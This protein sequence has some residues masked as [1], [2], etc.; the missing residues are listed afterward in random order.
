DL[1]AGRLSG[2]VS[3]VSADQ[4]GVITLTSADNVKQQFVVTAATASDAAKPEITEISYSSL[5]ADYFVTGIDPSASAGRVSLTVDG[6][7][8]IVTMEDTMVA[9]MAKLANAVTNGQDKNGTGNI[10]LHPDGT[11]VAALTTAIFVRSGETFTF[12]AVAD[13]DPLEIEGSASVDA[14]RQVTEISFGP[15]FDDNDVDDVDF[16]AGIGR[17]ISITIAGQTFTIDGTSRAELMEDLRAQLT[18]AVAADPTAVGIA[19]KLQDS[20]IVLGEEHK[21]TLTARYG[22]ADPLSV[23]DLTRAGFDP[24]DPLNVGQLVKLGFTKQYLT[25]VA[26]TTKTLS[27]EL[28]QTSVQYELSGS[29]TGAEIVVAIAAALE[30]DPLVS[31]AGL[32]ETDSWFIDVTASY[33]GPNVLGTVASGAANTVRLFEENG[34]KIEI[35][36]GFF[37]EET[38][39]GNIVLDPSNPQ[40]VG[41]ATEVTAGV[42]LVDDDTKVTTDT[43]QTAKAET[44]EAVDYTNPGFGG[45]DDSGFFGDASLDGNGDFEISDVPVPSSG[46]YTFAPVT[47]AFANL[48]TPGG[49]NYGGASLTN[50]LDTDG[51]ITHAFDF[52]VF[53][54]STYEITD[55]SDVGQVMRAFERSLSLDTIP[56]VTANTEAANGQFVTG[57][58]ASKQFLILLTDSDLGESYLWST[59][60]D[61]NGLFPGAAPTLLKTWGFTPTELD[62]KEGIL[63]TFENP[64]DSYTATSGSALF[65]DVGTG[66]GDATF[67]GD[68]PLTGALDE[69]GLFNGEGVLQT[70]T[71]P[72]NGYTAIDGSPELDGEDI[73]LGDGSLFGSEQGYYDDE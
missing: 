70:H 14:T 15:D 29:E 46:N 71:N 26:G 22:E 50:D 65:N 7:T 36:T 51:V 16:I 43:T 69:G 27:I 8:Y 60:T 25:S 19:A 9:T 55:P 45:E 64:D 31:T 21:L 52:S 72:D 57:G 11:T 24:A 54:G 73:D 23:S 53:V 4:N 41:S 10:E 30:A 47:F 42:D 37:V 40:T 1:G 39:A 66:E 20:G 28:G 56:D 32:T 68:D 44:D 58:Q 3:S 13:D 2:I 17:E 48:D 6:L 35:T 62:F 67:Y 38:V 49:S 34:T 59:G 63:Q 5:D 18:D 33:P 61:A 12:T